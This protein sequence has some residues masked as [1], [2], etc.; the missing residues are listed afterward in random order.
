MLNQIP[1]S[2]RL[3]IL[4]SGIWLFVSGLFSSVIG[5]E[6]FFSN[7]DVISSFLVTWL[8]VGVMPLGLVWGAA[9]VVS[10]YRWKLRQEATREPEESA[11]A[12]T[13]QRR[14]RNYLLHVLERDYRKGLWRL[15][16]IGTAIWYFYALAA[17]G[18]QIS[19]WVGFNYALLNETKSF[20][21]AAEQKRKHLALVVACNVAQFSAC[22]T[23]LDS[24]FPGDRRDVPYSDR[25]L[26][27]C[28]KT[29]AFRDV[30]TRE[31][32]ARG[33]DL[34][35]AGASG[36]VCPD[37]VAKGIP[38]VDWAEFLSV[39]LAPFGLIAIY[40]IG[41]WIIRGFVR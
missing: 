6:E 1:P 14:T 37:I 40:L 21:V 25:N 41:R 35:P 12:E 11:E 7:F 16:I 30:L 36:E 15:W 2:R 20:T 18:Y 23:S 13:S 31:L 28:E 8:F 5:A 24:L 26:P 27:D 39:A 32:K 9:W 17:S 10:G 3:A 19:E 29:Q 38:Y 33:V 22:P 34:P 4:L